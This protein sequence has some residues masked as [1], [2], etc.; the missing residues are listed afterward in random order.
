MGYS[1]APMPL[2]NSGSESDVFSN[3]K[4]TS[5]LQIPASFIRNNQT[6]TP[7]PTN[8]LD[9]SP[10]PT[11][12]H[13]TSLLV[14]SDN[15]VPSY[16]QPFIYTLL[17]DSNSQTKTSIALSSAHKDQKVIGDHY[18][19]NPVAIYE[20]IIGNI[21]TCAIKDETIVFDNGNVSLVQGQGLV[22]VEVTNNTNNI[23][24]HSQIGIRDVYEIKGGNS[25]CFG[26]QLNNNRKWI[27]YTDNL[28][29]N[30]QRNDNTG[31]FQLAFNGHSGI[32][33]LFPDTSDQNS[34]LSMDFNTIANL[35]KLGNYVQKMT[36]STSSESNDILQFNYKLKYAD[37]EAL[38]FLL[39]HHLL[40]LKMSY[41]EK[42]SLQLY[43]TVYGTMEGFYTSGKILFD[44]SKQ[45]DDL[46]SYDILS[47]KKNSVFH[48]KINHLL[49]DLTSIREVLVNNDFQQCMNNLENES[50]LD[51]MYFSGKV[52]NK[53]AWL[54]Y[55]S[56]EL[57]H[58]HDLSEQLFTKITQ[59]LN[60]FIQNQQILPLLYDT[61]WGGIISSGDMS[62]DFGNSMYNDH[63]FHYG[64]FVLTF[65]ILGW[66][67]P[68]WFSQNKFY[69]DLLL[70]DYCNIDDTDDKFVK[71]RNF[72]WFEGHS[73]ANGVWPSLDGRDQESS[74]EDYNSVYA[75]FLYGSATKNYKMQQIAKLQLN[76]MKRSNNLYFLYKDKDLNNEVSINEMKRN[77]VCGIFFQNKIDY[78]TYFG[79]NTEY[80]HM[81]HFIPGTFISRYIRD[82]EFVSEE[83]NQ[84]LK[85][86][87]IDNNGWNGLL[88]LNRALIS[89]DS[90][91]FFKDVNLNRNNLDNGQ[92]QT[93][94]LILVI[95][96]NT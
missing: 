54:L 37:R 10:L 18:A 96:W 68:D 16:V 3:A 12:D 74:S 1:R 82:N 81:I 23:V 78:A 24:I 77:K 30:V 86:I 42:A 75:M 28:S 29:I 20:L 46:S 53:Y 85:D 61:K 7:V 92:S 44:Y 87:H 13:I 14:S 50:N 56:A 51:S 58:D 11:N 93:L 26:V 17:R 73:W 21:G 40:D 25:K 22:T 95:L 76:I 83:W 5:D 60:K 94:S 55:V 59:C 62:Q 69:S 80:I 38:V 34:L 71:F 35:L 45:E 72:S 49:D 8:S 15:D 70:R 2:P 31:M 66:Y 43:S 47:D 33:Q 84:K 90:I 27:L 6:P 88:K 89:P 32:I 91:S 79:L 39:P 48:Q 36:V 63:H 19:Y 52:F 9:G 41:I 67:K 57:L 65:A 4:I 64:Y